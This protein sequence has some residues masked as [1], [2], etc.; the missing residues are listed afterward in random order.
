MVG[1]KIRIPHDVLKGKQG[2]CIDLAILFVSCLESMG[3]N[4]GIVLIAGH[5]YACVFL[6]EEHLLSS[7]YSD[8]T[9]MLD[10]CDNEKKVIFIECTTFTA[11]ND[12]TFEQACSLARENTWVHVND[13]NF[14][15]I[16]ISISRASGY[17]PLPIKFDDVEKITIDLEVKEENSIRLKKKDFKTSSD[18]LKLT[19]AEV[20]KFDLWEKKLLDLSKRNELIDFKVDRNGQQILTFDN[21]GNL[22]INFLFDEFKEKKYQYTLIDSNIQG[23][24]GTLSLP[25]L[26]EEQYNTC[27]YAVNDHKLLFIKRK[28][29]LNSALKFFDRERRKAFEE[30][31]SNVLYMAIGFIEWFETERSIRPKYAPIIL[32]PID[33]KRHSKDSYSIIGRDEPAFLNISIF[34]FFHQEFKMNFDDLLTMN[35]FS[36]DSNIS[37]DTILNTVSEKLKRLK[38]ARVIKT[39]AIN[40]FRFSK[41]VM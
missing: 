36:D 30:S 34:E 10:L 9:K 17:L 33:L 4:A 35:L 11:G 19:D 12:T 27:S 28:T 14:E 22:S 16:D 38:R 7:P 20:N 2:T 21:D 31:G 8:A 1:Q 26:T 40:I 5:A 29:S 23:M 32:I 18:K 39:A 13:P 37:A 25:D 6:E 41:A 15:V 24:G 3:L